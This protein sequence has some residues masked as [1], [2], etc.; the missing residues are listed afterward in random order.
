[1]FSWFERKKC[2]SHAG[3]TYPKQGQ[4]AVVHYTGTLQNG[5]VFDSSRTRGKPFK[6][7][8]GKGE[9]IQGW[10]E[11]VAQ[12]SIFFISAFAPT[13]NINPSLY[14]TIF[15]LLIYVYAAIGRTA[16]KAGV[17]TRLRVWQSRTSRRH[18]TQCHPHIWRWTSQSRVE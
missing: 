9:V 8:I 1:M 11:G 6:F 3:V 18:S 15:F 7:V 5:N 10:D 4:T 12:V 17:F 14:I 16:S 13:Q 2:L